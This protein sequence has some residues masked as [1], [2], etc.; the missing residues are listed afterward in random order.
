[1]EKARKEFPALR[2]QI[3]VNTPVYGPLYDGLL[4]WRQEHDLDFLLKASEMR[5]KSLKTIA[6]TRTVV[7]E[8]FNCK[9]ENVALINN[10][11][12]GLNMLLEGLDSNEKVLLL[13]NDYP[14]VDWPFAS[15]GFTIT[16]AAMDAYMEQN[17]LEA[18]EKENISILAISIVQW[19][20][21]LKISLEFLRDLKN[22]YP[23]LMIIADGTQFLGTT[24]FDFE[25]SGIDVLGASAYKWLLAGYGNGFMLFKDMVKDRCAL[26]TIGFNAAN[27]RSQMKNVIRFAR[28]FEAGHLSCLNFGSLKFSLSFLEAI[29]KDKIE[30]QN[31]KLSEKAKRE[32]SVLG[33]LQDIVVARKE[34]STIFNIKGDNTLFKHLNE[35]D[36]V[37]AQRGDGIRLGF[38]FYNSERDIDDIVRILK[39]VQ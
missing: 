15:R 7:G 34:H 21:G 29:G 3:Y 18:I 25:A 12:T 23:D 32:F 38:H 13:E 11:S 35:N 37:C 24:N 4:D 8:F 30:A 39:T 1:M 10:F 20:N 2:N 5:E 9:R 27:A 19:Q 33:L 16:Y 17:I 6:D 36:V 14:S 31:Q 22:Q 28:R 26:K